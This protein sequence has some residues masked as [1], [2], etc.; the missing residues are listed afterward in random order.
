MDERQA[1]RNQP[2]QYQEEV[3]YQQP[4]QEIVY[5]HPGGQPMGQSMGQP[6]YPG[7]GTEVVMA[8]PQ[9]GPGVVLNRDAKSPHPRFTPPPP[10]FFLKNFHPTHG[11]G[12]GG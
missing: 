8:P 10:I 11:W 7:P 6:G 12:D 2:P 4:Q 3:Y 1:E 5:Q 9:G